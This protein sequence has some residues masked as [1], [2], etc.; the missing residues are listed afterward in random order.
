[1]SDYK[2][3]GHFGAP[4]FLQPAKT[5]S[6]R[7]RGIYEPFTSH[8]REHYERSTGSEEQKIKKYE[9]FDFFLAYMNYFLYLC[10]E[11]EK[12]NFSIN[13]NIN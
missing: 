1:M 13:P 6:S 12:R 9:K 5:F 7:Y 11:N 10:R 2:S 3:E 8:L 4:L